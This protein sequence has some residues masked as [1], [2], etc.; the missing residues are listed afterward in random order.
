MVICE[1]PNP[2][3]GVTGVVFESRLPGCRYG[4]ALRDDD[5]GQTL[6]HTV[7]V[8]TLPEAQTLAKQWA[9]VK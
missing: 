7:H 6:P 9:N 8:A 5:S 3:D 4:A 2:I 1:Y